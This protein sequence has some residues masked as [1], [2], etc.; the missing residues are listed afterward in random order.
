MVNPRPFSILPSMMEE[1]I[2][3]QSQARMVMK[4]PANSFPKTTRPKKSPL[5]IKNVVQK[6]PRAMLM[7]RVFMAMECMR[8]LLFV[9][10]ADAIVGK[11]I[12]ANELVNVVG[13]IIN[14]IA[15][16]VRTPY[17]LKASELLIP[18]FWR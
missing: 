10:C 16:A 12:W 2:N 18:Y 15:M 7:L 1:K 14:G 17:M 8:S 3:G 6:S 4:S 11:S 13:N 9:A 5:N